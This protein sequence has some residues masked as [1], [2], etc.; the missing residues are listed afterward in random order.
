MSDQF[1]ADLTP[2]LHGAARE[3]ARLNNWPEPVICTCGRVVFDG[4]AI[5]ARCVKPAAGIA[6]CRCKRW[7]PVP[8]GLI[9]K[10]EA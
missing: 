10:A 2:I 4:E 1:H 6:L 8:V 5:K 7:V 3:R 9:T